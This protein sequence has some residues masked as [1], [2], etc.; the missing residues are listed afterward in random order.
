[1][2][3]LIA[4]LILICTGVSMSYAD[5]PARISVNVGVEIPNT[6]DATVA[7]EHPFGYGHSLCGF[8]EAGN[9]W[10]TPACHMFWKKYFWDGGVAYKHRI[11]R[12]K[13]GSFRLVGG[14]YCGSY[15]KKVFIGFDLGFEYNYTFGNNWQFTV[16]QKNNFNFLHHID[17][18]RNGLLIGLKIPL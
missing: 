13:N 16:S 8:L 15:L 14:G 11:L 18:F 9:R 17:T 5:D 10:Q 4:L 7:Y 2:K 1:M 12:F 3:K 6:L